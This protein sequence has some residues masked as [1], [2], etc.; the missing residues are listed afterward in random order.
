MTVVST[1]E[2]RTQS[3]VGSTPHAPTAA[4]RPRRS[5][6]TREYLVFLAFAGPNLVLI[7]L[8]TYRPLLTNVYYSTLDWN[9]GS[10]T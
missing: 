2:K 7:A 10:R 3:P 8:F 9:L 1:R 6:R 4:R 5:R